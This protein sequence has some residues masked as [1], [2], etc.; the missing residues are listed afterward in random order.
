MRVAIVG[1]G[2]A[3]LSCAHELERHGISPVIYERN[4]FIGE[5]HPHVS[6]IL[7]I[8]SREQGD[9][10]KY[11]KKKLALD[12]QPLGKV[13]RIIHYSP[14]KVKEIKGD[15]GYFFERD[16]SA[17]D[18]KNQLYSK[19]K[20]TQIL[21]NEYGD[22]ETLS[23]EYDYVLIA[24]GNN[25]YTEELGCWQEWMNT[26]VKGAR[27]YGDF[28]PEALMVWINQDYCKK[29]YAY[30]TP[31]DNKRAALAL[32]VTDID[33]AEVDLYWKLFLDTE[34]ISYAIEEEFTLN[35]KSG[36][37]YPHKIKNIYFAGN[38]AG[39]IDPF[40][41]FGQ[42]NALATG[43]LA[44]R[45]ITTGADYEKLLKSIVKSHLQQHEFR[46]AFDRANHLTYDIIMSSVGFPG[47]R[48]ILYKSPINVVRLGA[49]VLKLLPQKKGKNR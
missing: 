30:L 39:V 35:H 48:H 7:E 10:I 11:F 37:V 15:F 22:Y 16:K 9:A 28:D 19:L 24:N 46:K 47:I 32:V 34:N 40:L 45:S 27:V 31:F 4:S 38:S 23:K 8:V 44:A 2:L 43:V 1:A 42:M 25:D 5:Q 33:E 49:A 20:N 12:I 26:Y 14:N 21:F 18:V 29:G 36:F 13:K 17:Q 41:G 3:G 6:A